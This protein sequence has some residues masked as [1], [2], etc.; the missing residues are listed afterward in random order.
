MFRK[1]NIL[2]PKKKKKNYYLWHL[3]GDHKDGKEG[4]KL[5]NYELAWNSFPI[6][7]QFLWKQLM[8]PF[9]LSMVWNATAMRN[10][11]LDKERDHNWSHNLIYSTGGEGKPCWKLSN[12]FKGWMGKKTSNADLQG[13]L[14]NCLM[15][16]FKR[17][18]GLLHQNTFD[19]SHP[20]NHGKCIAKFNFT[21]DLQ[22]QR[23]DGAE[24]VVSTQLPPPT[25][26]THH[27]LPSAAPCQ[28]RH[29]PQTSLSR[30][31]AWLSVLQDWRGTQK[32]KRLTTQERR[33]QP[34][35]TAVAWGQTQSVF[36]HFSNVFPKY[37]MLPEASIKGR[38]CFHYIVVVTDIKC[39]L[40]T[41][42]SVLL[43]ALNRE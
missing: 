1:Q 7:C 16:D 8:C 4:P 13:Q 34:S 22:L 10:I 14:N 11:I 41:P 9:Q 33:R 39:G 20:Q 6:Q 32:E 26:I 19:F 29:T 36:K 5:S 18:L 2:Q 17:K 42:E 37:F 30:M 15:K 24:R 31:T 35:I 12:H 21:N 3:W 27:S 23:Q 28:H 25:T 38:Q 40:E 43:C